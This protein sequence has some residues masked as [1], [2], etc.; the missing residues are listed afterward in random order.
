VV[1][2][3]DLFFG[4]EATGK[5]AG[6]IRYQFDTAINIELSRLSLPMFDR[7]EGELGQAIDRRRCG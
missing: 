3:R 7:F 6:G 1:L 2:E 4:S 5:C